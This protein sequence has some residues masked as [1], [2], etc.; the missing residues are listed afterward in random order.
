MGGR[1]FAYRPKLRT[2]PVPWKA[3]YNAWYSLIETYTNR[4]IINFASIFDTFFI[5]KFNH[6][7]NTPFYIK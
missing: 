1:I 7:K 4:L 6:T 2:H 5:Y 3:G